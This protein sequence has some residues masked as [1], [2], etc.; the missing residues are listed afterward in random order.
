MAGC[1]G[2]PR[3]QVKRLA[4]R[5]PKVKGLVSDLPWPAFLD[6]VVENWQVFAALAVGLA[7]LA[8]QYVQFWFIAAPLVIAVSFYA[9]VG[10]WAWRVWIE[11][12]IAE[13][14][15]AAGGEGPGAPA[16]GQG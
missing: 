6:P 8:A 5:Y 13:T 4:Q 9:I 7:A 15:D 12:L 3:S 11:P 1:G 2:F 16:S 10:R 14:D